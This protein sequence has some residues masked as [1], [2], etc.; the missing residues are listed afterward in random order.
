MICSS[1]DISMMVIC[2]DGG[3]TGYAPPHMKQDITSIQYREI[4]P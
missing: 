2:D 1:V 4:A 3:I